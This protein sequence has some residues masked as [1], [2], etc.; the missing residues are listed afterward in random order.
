M[1]SAGQ[2]NLRSV[3]LQNNK[4]KIYALYGFGDILY[5]PIQKISYVKRVFI[6]LKINV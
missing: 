4:K 6:K 1:S 2:P 3:K 5:K